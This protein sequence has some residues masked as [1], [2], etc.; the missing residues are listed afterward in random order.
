MK[1]EDSEDPLVESTSRTFCC[2]SKGYD[3]FGSIQVATWMNQNLVRFWRSQVVDK[4][5]FK[6]WLPCK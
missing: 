5:V 1:S 3:R 6:L 4:E 2:G